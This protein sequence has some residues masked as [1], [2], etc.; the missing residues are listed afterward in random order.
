MQFD[1][2]MYLNAEE[3][4]AINNGPADST[5][6]IYETVQDVPT[7]TPFTYEHLSTSKPSQSASPPNA[8]SAAAAAAA[9]YDVIKDDDV[10]FAAT[11]D[12]SNVYDTIDDAVPTPSQTS[13]PPTSPQRSP[14]DADS[15]YLHVPAQSSSTSTPSEPSSPAEPP[16][17]VAAA[18]SFY[19][20]MTGQQQLDNS[21]ASPSS[22]SPPT[23]EY[24]NTAL[25]ESAREPD[26]VY[27][28]PTKLTDDVPCSYELE[29]VPRKPSDG[30]HAVTDQ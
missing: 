1:N 16:T 28:E 5:R 13:S 7:A 27:L 30:A 22:S 2:K 26:N 3:P 23:V 14:T 24:Y 19:Q 25:T 9:V 15:V 11:N 4:P 12:S 8:A 20:P 10:D 17:A 6:N 29:R 21:S 18:A